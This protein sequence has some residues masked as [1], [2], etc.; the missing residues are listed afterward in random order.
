[1][2]HFGD[3][4]PDSRSDKD[5]RRNVLVH[6]RSLGKKDTSPRE[7]EGGPD[8]RPPPPPTGEATGA[9]AAPKTIGNHSSQTEYKDSTASVSNLLKQESMIIRKEDVLEYHAS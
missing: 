3:G 1:M 4:T 6:A 2:A 5:A 7:A 8:A 9:S